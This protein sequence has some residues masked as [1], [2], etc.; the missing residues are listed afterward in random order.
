MAEK[1]FIIEIKIIDYWIDNINTWMNQ[2]GKIGLVGKLYLLAQWAGDLHLL[3]Y[4]VK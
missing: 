2:K 4:D 1:E 3:E